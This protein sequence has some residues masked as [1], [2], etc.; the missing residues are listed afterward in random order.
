MNNRDMILSAIDHGLEE[1]HISYRT[2]G[3]D[4][5]II[6][7]NCLK[8]NS[9]ITIIGSVGAR[10]LADALKINTTINEFDFSGNTMV[11][12][13]GMQALADAFRVNSSLKTIGL[14]RCHDVSFVGW[15]TLA[16]ALKINTIV[17]SLDM[18]AQSKSSPCS[19][20][21]SALLTMFFSISSGRAKL[22]SVSIEGM[23]LFCLYTV[24]FESHDV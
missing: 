10:A 6:L 13:D 5:A 9:S 3:D 21:Q 4:D 18:S 23:S 15:T 22:K 24:T 12:D 14:A 8:V 16:E 20:M 2:M 1:I 11:C 7:A 19:G 17:T